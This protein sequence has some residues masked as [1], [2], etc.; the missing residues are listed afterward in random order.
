MLQIWANW[1]NPAHYFDKDKGMPGLKPLIIP[2]SDHELENKS[3]YKTF[4]FLYRYYFCK[5]KVNMRIFLSLCMLLVINGL[6]SQEQLPV[7][8]ELGQ[9]DEKAYEQLSQEYNQSLLEVANFDMN[10][11]FDQWVELMKSI[12]A[13]AE[14]INFSENLKGVQAFLQVFWSPDGTIDHIGYLLRP[15]SKNLTDKDKQLLTAFF[16]SFSRQQ[17]F[18]LTSTKKFNHYTEVTFPTVVE[19]AN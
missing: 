3:N 2:A 17:R 14:R 11:A 10:K 18:P 7:A 6:Y 4:D 8:F 5:K 15:D 16:S 19:K 13:Y 9:V 1:R 12:D